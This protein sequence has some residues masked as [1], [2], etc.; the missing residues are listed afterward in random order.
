STDPNFTR[1][2]P[3][4]IDYGEGRIFYDLDLLSARITDTSGA[5]SSGVRTVALS[6]VQGTFLVVERVSFL[7]SAGAPSSIATRNPATFVSA[8]LIDT[9]YPAAASSNTGVPQIVARISDTTL[10]LGPA[11]DA[12]Y[13]VEVYGTQRPTPLSSNNSSTWISQNLPELF[14]AATMV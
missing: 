8:D 2:A 10:L 12:P 11:P 1:F 13:G 4:A 6:T 14:M 3:G 9:I 7:T 5:C